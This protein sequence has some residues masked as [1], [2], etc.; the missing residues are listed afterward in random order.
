M[1]DIL[2]PISFFLTVFGIIFVIYRS[3]TKERL[4]LMEH[5]YDMKIF[6]QPKN[7]NYQFWIFRIGMLLTGA[8]LGAI[9]THYSGVNG[10]TGIAFIF[11]FAGIFWVIEF[12]IEMKIINKSNSGNE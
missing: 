7:K 6:E 11:L 1:E 9:V 12:L 4:A 10:P 3:R 5:G 8:A 2:V